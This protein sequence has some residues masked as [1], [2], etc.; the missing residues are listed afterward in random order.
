M[1]RS[2]RFL[3]VFVILAVMIGGAAFMALP[4]WA[5]KKLPEYLQM[6]FVPFLQIESAEFKKSPPELILHKV[7]LNDPQGFDGNDA[8]RIDR[9]NVVFEKSPLW[10][11]I[12]M[13]NITFHNVRGE[14]KE[15]GQANNF[16]ILLQRLMERK[17]ETARGVLAR[18]ATLKQ[19]T[20]YRS[21][22]Q[23]EDAS[24]FIPLEDKDYQPTG[25]LTGSVPLQNVIAD[26]LGAMIQHEQE[27][28][29][30]LEVKE[31]KEKTKGFMK[32]IGDSV[33][34]YL[35]TP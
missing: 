27:A 10:G 35:T 2:V 18:P 11:D 30:L 21:S 7:R 28:V 24:S 16:A 4:G 32:S 3:L 22:V 33:K 8:F 26:A 34:E 6:E 1:T 9:I 12:H 17:G 23:N 19:M 15:R 25:A 13:T 14:Y 20:I 5:V 29:D 31:I